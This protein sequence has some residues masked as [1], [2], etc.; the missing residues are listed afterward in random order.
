MTE[1]ECKAAAWDKFIEMVKTNARVRVDRE[2]GIG[3]KKYFL[4]QAQKYHDSFDKIFTFDPYQNAT[5]QF[6]NWEPKTAEQNEELE[7]LRRKDKVLK[8][9]SESGNY[10]YAFK[11]CKLENG[12]WFREGNPNRFSEQ[13]QLFED[14]MHSMQDIDGLY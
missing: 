2:G 10:R 13:W 3:P 8:W 11:F 6:L 4:Y 5:E 9:L 14:L 7:L 12:K 1:T